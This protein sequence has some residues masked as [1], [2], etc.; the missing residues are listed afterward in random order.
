VRD[1]VNAPTWG[2]PPADRA[3]RRTLAGNNGNLHMKVV[4]D[5]WVT[6]AAIVA[7]R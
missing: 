2:L 7:A 6:Q 1:G 4:A 5:V 3:I